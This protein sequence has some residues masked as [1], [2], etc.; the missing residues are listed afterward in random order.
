MAG[1]AG[2]S[3]RRLDGWFSEEVQA[4]LGILGFPL[5]QRALDRVGLARSC[6]RSDSTPG[7]P[8]VY[9]HPGRDEELASEVTRTLQR[10]QIIRHDVVETF[11]LAPE[12][13]DSGF[14]LFRC[15]RDASL[16][17]HPIDILL[18]LTSFV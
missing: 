17:K 14:N 11:C 8:C 2:D 3:Y 1:D 10:R 7:L 4:Q 18:I 9:E 16:K 5:E 12:G 15:Q 6:L 13:G